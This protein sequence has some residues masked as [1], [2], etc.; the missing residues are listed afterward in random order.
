MAILYNGKIKFLQICW[1]KEESREK[2]KRSSKPSYLKHVE[3]KQT[4]NLEGKTTLQR[5]QMFG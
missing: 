4:T 2:S 5:N 3:K 1:G